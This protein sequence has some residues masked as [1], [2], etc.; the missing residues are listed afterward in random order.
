L[1][2]STIAFLQ[3]YYA[4]FPS[5]IASECESI[6]NKSKLANPSLIISDCDLRFAFSVL[7]AAELKDSGAKARKKP[8]GHAS[9]ET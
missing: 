6:L 7:L 1:R 8:V 3:Y 9:Q 4:V 5:G 2:L